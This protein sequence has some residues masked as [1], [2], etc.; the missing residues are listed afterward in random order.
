MN[1]K[2][3]CEAGASRIA[4][5]GSP[6]GAAY[7]RSAYAPVPIGEEAKRIDNKK[8]RKLWKREDA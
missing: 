1:L 4:A 6:E 2:K 3:A 5:A 7:A 8:R